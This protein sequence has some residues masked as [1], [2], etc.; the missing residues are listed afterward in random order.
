MHRSPRLS[1]LPQPSAGKTGWPWTLETAP[2][3]SGQNWPLITIVTPS[4]N[5]AMFLEETMRSVLLQGYPNF[6]YIVIDGGS[7]DGSVEVIRK[8]EEHL[9]YWVS[10]KDNGPAEA[11]AKGFAK[12]SGTILAYLNSDDLYLPGS[13]KAIADAMRDRAVDVAFGNMNWIGA[14][15]KTVGEQRQTPFLPMG[16]LYG[17][18]TLPQPAVF[19]RKDLYQRCGG[20]DTSYHFAFDAYLFFRFALEGARF[21]HVNKFVASFR[22]HPQSKSSNELEVCAKEIQRLRETYLPFPYESFRG[23]CV[24]GLTTLQRTF[25]YA[26]Q[27]DLF[28]LLGRIPDRIHARHSDT[29]VGPRGRRV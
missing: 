25:W 11:I 19:W 14:D 26:L 8:Y 4:Y 2:E 18:A 16:F 29:I 20:M 28:W 22:I 17:G 9:A 27:G 5:Q 24:R 21:K 1:E 13:L 3:T 23:S 10:E 7:S 6:E 12:A 15:G